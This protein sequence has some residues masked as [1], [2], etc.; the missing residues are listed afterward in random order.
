MTVASSSS[1]SSRGGEAGEAT[2]ALIELRD[3]G[4]WYQLRGRRV[5]SIKHALLHGR[6]SAETRTLW[7]LRHLDLRCHE[8]EVVGIV[9]R[10]GA[11]KS[12]LCLILA[13]ILTPD[14]G[15]AIVRGTTTPLLTLGSGFHPELSGREN[16]YVYS[17]FLGTS[18]RR[19]DEKLAEIVA[20]SELEAFIDEPLYTYSS[21]MRARLGF[22][23]AAALDP[24][25]MILDEVLGVGDR[26]F[27]AKSRA[28]ILQMMKQSKLIVIV[29]HS[30]GFLRKVCTHCLWLDKGKQVAYGDAASVLDRYESSSG[31]PSVD[32]E[33]D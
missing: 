3:L 24:E 1:S 15:E 5:L 28:R 26:E 30:T 2:K 10:N 13:R 8:G 31:G 22:S 12:T 17:A 23:V 18:R 27:R 4:V 9:G 21:G 7:A 29:S 11:G 20:F 6:L 33:E 32:E 25:I 14:E 19:V 16:I